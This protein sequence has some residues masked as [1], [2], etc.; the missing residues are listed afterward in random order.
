MLLDT[1]FEHSTA[2]HPGW[3]EVDSAQ[4]RGDRAISVRTLGRKGLGWLLRRRIDGFL[5]EWA[6]KVWDCMEGSLKCIVE[7]GW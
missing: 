3:H 6:A 4:A 7:Y 5:G 2:V 1:P